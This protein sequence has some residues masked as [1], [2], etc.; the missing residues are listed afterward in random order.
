[1]SN[2]DLEAFL[3]FASPGQPTIEEEP[4]VAGE[5]SG[6]ALPELHDEGAGTR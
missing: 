3:A 4:V 1:M 6:G 5:Q 2:G